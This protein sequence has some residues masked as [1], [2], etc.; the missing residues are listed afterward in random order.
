[1]PAKTDIEIFFRSTTRSGLLL[2]ITNSSGPGSVTVEQL[3]GQII[4]IFNDERN[5]SV[6][7]WIDPS[8]PVDGQYNASFHLCDNKFHRVLVKRNISS[9]ELK[10]DDHSPVAGEVPSGYTL[11]Y[12]TFHIGGVPDGS[13]FETHSGMSH[14]GLTG[15]VQKLIIDGQSAGLIRST[16]LHNVQKGCN[17]PR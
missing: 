5:S 4:L 17:A 12:G 13:G 15:C 9:V 11:E 6:I 16:Q 8:I 3:D 2:S 14:K 1:L 7:R 10:V